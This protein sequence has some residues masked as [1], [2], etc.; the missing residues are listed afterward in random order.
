MP[1][2]ALMR[3]FPATALA[4]T[5]ACGAAA[6]AEEALRVTQIAPGV[7]VHRGEVAMPAQ[8]NAND[9]ANAGFVVGDKGVAVID[10]GG[11]VRVG[12]GLLAAIRA[13]TDKPVLYVV[14]THE[15]P[16]HFFGNAAFTGLGAMFVGHRNLPRAL[17]TRGEFYLR[18]FR[19]T[20]GDALIDEVKLIP[21][22]MTV[23][24]ETTLDL[25][26][27]A[28]TL[29][30]WPPAHSDCDL[31]V[32]DATSGTLFAGDTVFLDHVPVLDASMKG[33][34]N[35]I[36]AL[37]AMNAQRVVPGHGP[38][39]APWPAAL[40]A[41]K[42]YLEGVVADVRKAL[43]DGRDLAAAAQSVGQSQRDKWRLFDDYNA[44][45]ATTTYAEYEWDH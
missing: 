29:R 13:V 28:L 39:T 25:G 37:G 38:E 9:T 26:G 35:A 42:A 18:G 31:T 12:R 7:F 15:H 34:L 19:P 2:D 10:T 22:D 36:Q 24:G 45:N 40:N 33:W 27:R 17:A 43:E 20:L 44:R 41:E 8:A 6:R 32:F 3:L 30:A 16:D 1:R 5:L 23:E 14:N 11:S 4:L 21:P